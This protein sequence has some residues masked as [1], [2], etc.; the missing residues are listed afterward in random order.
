MAT[1]KDGS[2]YGFRKPYNPV[3]DRVP[4]RKQR[5][6]LGAYH[7]HLQTIEWAAE[8][9][10]KL[11]ERTERLL[12]AEGRE[13]AAG[14]VDWL[15]RKIHGIY[16]REHETQRKALNRATQR[17][18]ERIELEMKHTKQRANELN[19]LLDEIASK[20]AKIA[21]LQGAKTH[22]GPLREDG[23]ALRLARE[24]ETDDAALEDEG[25]NTDAD[26]E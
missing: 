7:L 23:H 25:E 26:A 15:A 6:A 3:V 16:N 13:D 14:T 5:R 1:K 2:S 19:A 8:E 12:R 18:R 24:G 22:V 10:R 17:D 20:K 21:K 4:D 9:V 11:C